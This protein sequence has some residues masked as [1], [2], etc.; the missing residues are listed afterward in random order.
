MDIAG[1][2]TALLAVTSRDSP[3][4]RRALRGERAQ[5]SPLLYRRNVRRRVDATAE[6]GIRNRGSGTEV[7]REHAR[8]DRERVIS[9]IEDGHRDRNGLPSAMCLNSEE[10]R[11]SSE[12]R[13]WLFR[14]SLLT[15]HSV[16]D[17]PGDGTSCIA[18]TSPGSG[19]R[20]NTCIAASA[21]SS[22]RTTSRGAH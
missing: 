12:E 18:R 4:L 21:V 1:R 11:V 7:Q 3:A 16:A 22:G 20:K 5:D 8:P 2:A 9:F 13:G 19:A 14:S 17:T 15:R 10:R 6:S